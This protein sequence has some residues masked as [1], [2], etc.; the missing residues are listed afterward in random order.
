M[1]QPSFRAAPPM[2]QGRRADR[3]LLQCGL[4]T[5]D[6][7]ALNVMLCLRFQLVL[8]AFS[9]Q[10]SLEIVKIDPVVEWNRTLV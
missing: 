8:M 3:A 4:F 9:S 2:E 6:R 7:V 10:R 5:I 1:G